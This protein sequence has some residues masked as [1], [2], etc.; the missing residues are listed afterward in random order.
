MLQWSVTSALTTV[1]QHKTLNFLLLTAY[2]DHSF[3][4]NIS[5]KVFF[6]L[7]TASQVL[8][9]KNVFKQMII[10]QLGKLS[11]KSPIGLT[12][13]VFKFFSLYFFF[14][15]HRILIFQESQTLIYFFL[16]IQHTNTYTFFK[17]STD[18]Y[19]SRVYIYIYFL[20]LQNNDVSVLLQT[21]NSESETVSSVFANMNYFCSLTE[22]I[23]FWLQVIKNG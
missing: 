11:H 22:Q 2:T 17:W 7:L 20:L 8:I 12:P 9:P 10:Y 13:W 15:V 1:Q 6:R 4:P 21:M 19:I 5:S 14:I 16:R 23:N 18:L 3:Q